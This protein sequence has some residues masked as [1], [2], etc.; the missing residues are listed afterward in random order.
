MSDTLLFD[1]SLLISTDLSSSIYFCEP[2]KRQH[3]FDLGLTFALGVKRVHVTTAYYVLTHAL[4]IGMDRLELKRAYVTLGKRVMQ[5]SP[6]T[7]LTGHALVG[8]AAQT[9]VS[10]SNSL[11]LIPVLATV[12]QVRR[13]LHHGSRKYSQCS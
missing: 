13:R 2:N 11:R 8:V 5:Q 3:I 9:Y 7:Y 4:A 10:Q 1:S 6:T 12:G